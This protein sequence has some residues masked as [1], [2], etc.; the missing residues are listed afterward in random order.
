ME[1]GWHVSLISLLKPC[2]ISP[3]LQLKELGLANPDSGSES[4][5]FFTLPRDVFAFHPAS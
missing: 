3:I 2:A 5:D 1:R 4:Y